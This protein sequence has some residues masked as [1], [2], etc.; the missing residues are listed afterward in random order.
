MVGTHESC[1][2]R[3]QEACRRRAKAGVR[4]PGCTATPSRS[5]VKGAMGD[6]PRRIRREL[7]VQLRHERGLT[8]ATAARGIGV[9]ARTLARYENGV[10]AFLTVGVDR[11]N[12]SRNLQKI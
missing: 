7:L 2:P 4:P 11:V 12:K 6:T 9:S 1:K 3:H 8:I 10:V 5:L